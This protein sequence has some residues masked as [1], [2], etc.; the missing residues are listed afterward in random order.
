MGGKVAAG[1]LSILAVHEVGHLVLARRFNV[2]ALW[3]IFIPWSGACILMLKETKDS[4]EQAW[5]GLGGPLFG[6]SATIALHCAGVCWHSKWLLSV[7]LWGYSVH[8]LNLIPAGSLDG[9]HVAGFVGRW[10]FVPGA[11]V[12]FLV[13]WFAENLS[14]SGKV[15]FGLLL[16]HAFWCAAAFLAEK[17]GFKDAPKEQKLSIRS[18]RVVWLV[19]LC[20]IYVC[21]GGAILVNLQIEELMIESQETPETLLS[22]DY[23][24]D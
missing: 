22:Q 10:L 17:L 2:P 21:A 19:F 24:K 11:I 16:L 18:R 7:A 8:L 14:V 5:I 3:P 12:L 23:E 1:V 13:V 15:L 4:F 20:L 6:V 9:G